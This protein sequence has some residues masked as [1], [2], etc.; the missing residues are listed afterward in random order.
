MAYFDLQLDRLSFTCLKSSLYLCHWG[1]GRMLHHRQGCTCR[2]TEN[3][4][5]SQFCLCA[6]VETLKQCLQSWHINVYGRKSADRT[7]HGNDVIFFV[8]SDRS[9]CTDD[10]L[11]YIYIYTGCTKKN[12]SQR[13]ASYFSSGN[14]SLLFHMCYIIRILSSFHLDI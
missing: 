3:R 11:L 12:A 2:K 14:R 1:R 8:S 7:E 5:Y 9:S 13:F 10:G 4:F 6:H